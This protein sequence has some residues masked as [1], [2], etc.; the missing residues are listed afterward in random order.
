MPLFYLNIRDTIFNCAGYFF[1][2]TFLVFVCEMLITSCLSTFSLYFISEKK[3]TIKLLVH[4][5]FPAFSFDNFACS[6]LKFLFF[7]SFC[8]IQNFLIQFLPI[9]NNEKT[10]VVRIFCQIN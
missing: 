6:I 7:L 9:Q 1:V 3:N 8:L 10:N 4:T 2:M 5:I